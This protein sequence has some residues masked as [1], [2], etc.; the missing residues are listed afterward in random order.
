MEVPTSLDPIGV[1]GRCS[2]KGI[3]QFAR[4]KGNIQHALM[5]AQSC[6]TFKGAMS[7]GA[8]CVQCTRKVRISERSAAL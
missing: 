1:F 5:R 6:I 8:N 3:P 4:P 2:A 7:G